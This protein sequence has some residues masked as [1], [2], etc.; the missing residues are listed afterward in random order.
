MK[1]LLNELES[2]GL[3]ND[4]IQSIFITIY[5]WLDNHY[6]VIA[7]ISKQ[8]MAQDLGIKELSM[9]SYVIIAHN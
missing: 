8:S 9:S 2:K 7:K 6:P 3:S 1:S 4:Q 5:E